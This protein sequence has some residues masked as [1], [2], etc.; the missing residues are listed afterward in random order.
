V[1]TAHPPDGQ[2]A[3]LD[4]PILLDRLETI[5]GTGRGETAGGHAAFYFWIWAVLMKVFG[6]TVKVAHILPSL[7][8]FLAVAGTYRLEGKEYVVKDGIIYSVKFPAPL[9]PDLAFF[10]TNKDGTA[11]LWVSTL[12]GVKWKVADR[13]PVGEAV[14][15]PDGTRIAYLRR[16][17]RIGPLPSPEAGYSP[18]WYELWIANADGTEPHCICTFSPYENEYEANSVAWGPNGDLL[19]LAL[20]EVG[21]PVD[22]IYSIRLD[23][24]GLKIVFQSICT[25]KVH[26][27]WSGSGLAIQHC[28]NL[29]KAGQ[30]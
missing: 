22:D 2:P 23:G 8:A 26:S 7:S 6:N 21:T 5:V 12:D 10:R 4:G 18:D 17:R 29:Q 13:V 9:S 11:A 1:A 24:T 28:M 20:A 16:G 30:T 15:S 27:S 3:A 14:W 25:Y 19:Y